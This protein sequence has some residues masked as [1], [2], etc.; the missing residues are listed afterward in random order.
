MCLEDLHGCSFLTRERK[1]AARKNV[2][3]SSCGTCGPRETLQDNALELRAVTDTL[4]VKL[5]QFQH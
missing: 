2:V 4:R 5:S 3:N 1:K